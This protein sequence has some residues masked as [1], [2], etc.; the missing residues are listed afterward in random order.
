MGL[1]SRCMTTNK[2]TTAIE[3]MTEIRDKA[4]DKANELQMQ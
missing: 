1:F 3:K 2:K 4:R